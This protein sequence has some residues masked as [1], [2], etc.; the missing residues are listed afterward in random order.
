MQELGP[1]SMHAQ[2]SEVILISKRGSSGSLDL[3]IICF[4]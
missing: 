2:V 3:T 4:S 1:D